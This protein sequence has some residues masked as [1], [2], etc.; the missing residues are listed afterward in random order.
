MYDLPHKNYNNCRQK[1]RVCKNPTFVDSLFILHSFDVYGDNHVRIQ[2]KNM[3]IKNKQIN[4]KKREQNQYINL[5]YIKSLR[6]F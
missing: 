2:K 4:E 1:E 3:E 5:F 6:I